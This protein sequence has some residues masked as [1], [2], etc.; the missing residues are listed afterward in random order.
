MRCAAWRKGMASR[1]LAKW[2]APVA[3]LPVV[4]AVMVPRLFAPVLRAQGRDAAST[5]LTGSYV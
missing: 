4:D 5:R 2:E 1:G 3:N